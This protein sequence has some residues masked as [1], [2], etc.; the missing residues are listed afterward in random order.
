MGKRFSR[1]VCRPRVWFNESEPWCTTV[2]P[3][4]NPPRGTGRVGSPR[5]VCLGMGYGVYRRLY[6]SVRGKGRCSGEF[7]GVGVRPPSSI[8]GSCKFLRPF[9]TQYKGKGKGRKGWEERGKKNDG[10]WKRALVE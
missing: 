6:T 10:L 1:S 7:V 4:P 3:E 5:P 9:G 2:S 8:P